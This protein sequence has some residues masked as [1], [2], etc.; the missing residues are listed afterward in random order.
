MDNT[1]AETF[2]IS[3]SKLLLKINAR[4][5]ELAAI[6]DKKTGF[7]F[8]WQVDPAVWNRHAPVLFPVVGKLFNNTIAISGALYQMNQHGFAR[9]QTFELIELYEDTVSL[10]LE[11]G[12]NTKALYPFDFKFIISYELKELTV[13]TTYTI[14]NTG[15]SRLYFSVGAH[16]GF[17]LPVKDLSKFKIR[18]DKP[19]DLNRFLL[20]EGNFNG[21]TENLGTQVTELSLDAELFKKDA[22]VFKNLRSDF[23]ILEQVDG[24]FSV[25]LKFEGFPYMGIWSKYP[26]QDFICLEPWAGLA[27]S[28]GFKGDIAEKEGMMLLEQGETKI[29]AFELSLHAPA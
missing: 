23:L 7:E 11:S 19:E 18:F 21:L 8:I 12:A 27:D 6:T 4:G 17:N 5:A 13:K 2:Q 20:Q 15:N 22:L 28:V 26:N 10:M 24:D 1:N 25:G 29:F 3:S 14:I 9:D 16:P